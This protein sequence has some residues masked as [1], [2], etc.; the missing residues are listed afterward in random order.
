[1]FSHKTQ[2]CI[3]SNSTPS[4]NSSHSCFAAHFIQQTIL[5]CFSSIFF[6]SCPS[7]SAHPH[8]FRPEECGHG[9]QRLLK[10]KIIYLHERDSETDSFLPA[11][12]A[13][14]RLNLS[15]SVGELKASPLHTLATTKPILNNIPHQLSYNSSENA[16]FWLQR[17]SHRTSSRFALSFAPGCFVLVHS[18]CLHAVYKAYS[19]V[20]AFLKLLLQ[21][22]SLPLPFSSPSRP[23]PQC[24]AAPFLQFQE[25]SLKT[26]Q[27]DC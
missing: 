7:P 10:L 19:S 26:F 5:A 6:T 20:A 27:Q 22:T 21:T 2:A 9:G 4:F 15:L 3:G 14:C 17:N 11:A 13:I 23:S 1:M 16:F 25:A 24:L 18:W 12:A 8:S